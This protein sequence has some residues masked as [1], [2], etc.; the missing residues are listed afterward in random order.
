[1]TETHE[2]SDR[3]PSLRYEG[4]REP[5]LGFSYSCGE[6]M[7][8]Y[9]CRVSRAPLENIAGAYQEV[10]PSPR[11]AAVPIRLFSAAMMGFTTCH[12]IASR[13]AVTGPDAHGYFLQTRLFASIGRTTF[14]RQSPM[15]YV[16]PDCISVCSGR[17]GPL[18]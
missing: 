9:T 18:E 3:V 13:P 16:G 12:L 4:R 2:V 1:M 8:R 17:A 11:A 14:T 15:Q 10:T 7:S 6:A 5:L